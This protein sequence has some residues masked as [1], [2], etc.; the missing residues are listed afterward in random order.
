VDF[1]LFLDEILMEI[2]FLSLFIIEV[3]AMYK[4]KPRDK[5]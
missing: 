2:S 1:Y 5:K 3:S 4:T